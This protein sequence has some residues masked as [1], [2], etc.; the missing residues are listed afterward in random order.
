MS[1]VGGLLRER[2]GA[3]LLAR[4]G[5]ERYARPRGH[6]LFRGHVAMK[7][8]AALRALAAYRERKRLERI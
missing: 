4:A 7:R 8:A 6:S 1:H 5:R 3:A 2:G